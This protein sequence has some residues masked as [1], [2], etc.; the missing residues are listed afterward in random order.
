MIPERL[1]GT[2]RRHG[3]GPRPHPQASRPETERAWTVVTMGA[4][5]RFDGV[6]DYAFNLASALG[7]RASASLLIGSGRRDSERTPLRD[8]GRVAME[9]VDSFRRLW[10]FDW[11]SPATAGRRT[12]VLQYVPQSLLRTDVGWLLTWLLWQRVQGQSVVLTAHEWNV[13]WGLTPR[14]IG[15]R[16]VFTLLLFCFGAVATHIVTPQQRYLREISRRLFWKRTGRMC[17]IPVGTNVP[18]VPT[19]AP[20]ARGRP[21]RLVM[22]GRAGGMDCRLLVRLVSWLGASR[23]GVVLRWLGRS[24]E[25]M[26]HVWQTRCGLP[27]E[28]VEFHE[29]APLSSVSHLLSGSDLFLAPNDDGV[30]TRSTTLVAAL[31]HGLPV[32]GTDGVSTDDDLRRTGACELVG[33]GDADGFVVTVER[34]LADAAR[35]RAMSDAARALFEARFAWP[36]IADAYADLVTAGGRRTS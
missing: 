23:E 13:A 10:R 8:R 27:L 20:A 5:D 18:V 26:L 9:S 24:R 1:R 3:L 31:A 34:L 25:E 12:Y 35:R 17:V 4:P 2:R 6:G 36:R 19:A 11:T 22:F 32:V 7:D 28:R 29:R 30:S 16:L 33:C 15:A 14:R 21:V